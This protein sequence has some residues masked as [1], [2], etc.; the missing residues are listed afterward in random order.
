MGVNEETYDPKADNIISNASCTTNCLAPIV[1]VL[2]EQFHIVRGL[3]TTVHSYTNDQAILEKH[4]RRIQE[5]AVL[6]QKTLFR[7]PQAQ[8]RQSAL[9]FLK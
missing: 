2:H 3:M 9:S 8:Q 5:E 1:K 6:L 4:T 7:L